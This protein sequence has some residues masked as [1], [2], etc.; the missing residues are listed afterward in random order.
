MENKNES[1]DIKPKNMYVYICITQTICI[2]V[3][4]I[5]LLVVKFFFNGSYNHIKKWCNNNLFEET[6][7][8]A[9]FDEEN[10]G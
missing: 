4:L 6:K 3:I 5:T 9:N 8:T 2:A 7:I 1:A 10:A